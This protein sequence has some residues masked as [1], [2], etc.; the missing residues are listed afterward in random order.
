MYK[1]WKN[2]KTGEVIAHEEPAAIPAH[3]DGVYSGHNEH[4]GEPI[5]VK[6]PRNR[7]RKG[8]S[9]DFK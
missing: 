3:L 1:Y 6:P 2:K 9:G 4:P 7:K 8:Y 5:K